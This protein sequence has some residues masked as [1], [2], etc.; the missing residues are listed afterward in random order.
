VWIVL[1]YSGPAWPTSSSFKFGH[2][3]FVEKIWYILIRNFRR[4]LNYEV[5]TCR[6]DIQACD[7]HDFLTYPFLAQGLS[8]NQISELKKSEHLTAEREREIKQVIVYH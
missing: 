3:H 5:A 6:C 8:N 4:V 1:C 7:S 2:Y